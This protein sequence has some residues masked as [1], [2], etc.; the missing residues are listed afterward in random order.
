[1]LAATGS[2]MNGN[3]VVSNADT[4]EKLV[5]SSDLLRPRFS[6][7]D[8]TYTF[9]VPQ[10]QTAAGVVDIFSHVLEQYFSP[11]KEAFLQDRLAE[12]ILKTC[13]KYGPIAL[14]EPENYESRATLLWV[15]SLALNGLLSYGKIGDWATHYIE[16]EV[17]AIYDVTHGVGLAILTPHW[18]EYVLKEST[19][20]KFYEYAKNV[21]G[22]EGS[23]LNKVSQEGIIK[24]KEFFYS[25]GMPSTLQEIGVKQDSLEEMAK[26]AI[27]FGDLGSFQKLNKD[28]ILNIL[29][30]SF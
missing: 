3:S 29:K 4:K 7:L 20:N 27:I 15:S 23:N 6:V 25:L 1:T 2:E 10:N 28:D 13:I 16:H 30:N 19:T 8:P 18:M 5:I 17:S 11:I 14:K 21:W 24:T 26:K 12:A 9:S 22:V